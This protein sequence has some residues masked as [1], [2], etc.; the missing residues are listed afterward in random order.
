MYWA[1]PHFLSRVRG[2][3][4]VFMYHRVL[5]RPAV[6]S[7]YVQ[8]GMYVT[9]ETFERHLEF[10]R[11]HFEVLSFHELL[12]KWR[13]RQ[14][15]AAARYCVLTFDDGWLDNYRHAWPLLRAYAMPAT[16]FLPT[17]LI[18]TRATLWPERLGRLLSRRA[19]GTSDDW[20]DQI[21]RAKAL[22]DEERHDFIEALAED[23]GDDGG[24]TRTLMNW[25]EVEELSEHGISFGSHTASHA[26]LTRLNGAA[27]DRELC[28]SL[29]AIHARSVDAVPV[30]AYPNGDCTDAV[31]AAAKAAGYS[32]AVTTVPGLEGPRPRDLFRLRRVGV[33]EDM[34]RSIP[35]LALH[36]A[37][38]AGWGVT[39]GRVS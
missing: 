33:H 5:P 25:Q 31:A 8:P 7:A 19:Y 22:G 20:D 9:P 38:Q 3:A 4:I 37:R 27:L 30:L 24:P 36:I 1:S 39:T 34:T 12:R 23:L 11:T 32:A 29:D 10:V 26:N 18:G 15:D 35:R 16:I 13:D 28:L 6:A 14:W 17:D 2:Q 21:E